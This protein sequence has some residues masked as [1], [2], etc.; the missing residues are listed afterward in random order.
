MENNREMRH[1]FKGQ[2]IRFRNGNGDWSIGKVVKVREDGLEI[3]ELNSDSYG[4]Y[5]FGFFGGPFFG[6]PFFVP[7]GFGF[8]DFFWF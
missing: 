2:M 8:F 1:H 4:G 3:S 6:A 7:F 5:G